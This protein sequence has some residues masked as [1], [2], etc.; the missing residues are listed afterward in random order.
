M[1]RLV[2]AATSAG[3]ETAISRASSPTTRFPSVVKA[4]I[5]SISERPPR[6]A[7]T[8]GL[9][10]STVAT[11]LVEV[12]RSMPT[13]GSR[14]GERKKRPTPRAGGC[15][16]AMNRCEAR[17]PGATGPVRHGACVRRPPLCPR[18][19]RGEPLRRRGRHRRSAE[20]A[21][22]ADGVESAPGGRRPE[23]RLHPRPAPWGGG[24]ADPAPQAGGAPA[25]ELPS[26]A[27]GPSPAGDAP[28][29]R[30]AVPRHGR[31]E[32]RT[33]PG[34]GG[35]RGSAGPGL[36]Q[37]AR[38]NTVTR[39][40]EAGGARH[41]RGP[42]GPG[43]RQ[44]PGRLG[45][46][47][48]NAAFPAR[49]AEA[50]TPELDRRG[51]RQ[52]FPSPD[53]CRER[54]ELW[55]HRAAVSISSPEPVRM[56][57][58]DPQGPV[59]S[60][61]GAADPLIGRVLNDRFRILSPLG[62][63]GM[64]KVY[65][66]VQTPLDRVVALKILNPNFPAEKD[67]AFKRRFFL[68]ASLTSKL[69]HPNTVTVI[70]YGQTEDGIYFIAMEYMEGQTL[71][72]VLAHEK[73]LPWRR[74]LDIAQQICRSLREAH[75]LGVIHRD[76]KPA[77]VMLLNE[78]DHDMVKVLD[79]GLVKSFLAA[80]GQAGD[81]EVTQN[82]VFLGSPQYMAPEQARNVADPRSDVY[83]LG[84]LVYQ[85]L[86][87]RPP[88]Q[89]KDYL[90]VI[91]QHMKESPRPV[92]DLNPN[93]E[94]P[95]EV[96]A[97]VLRC[98]Q[99]DPAAR[100][101]SMDEVLEALREVAL[102]T[103]MSGIFPER[104]TST[105]SGPMSSS[106]VHARSGSGP[107]SSSGLHSRSISGP[108][109]A[110]R[111]QVDRE[112]E[113][114]DAGEQRKGGKLLPALLFVSAVLL[115]FV[116]VWLLLPKGDQAQ[117][118]STAPAPVP[119][120]TPVVVAPKA[121]QPPPAPEK[122]MVRFHVSTEPAGAHVFI[123]RHDMGSTPTVF[124]IAA[125]SDGM[126]SAEMVLVLDGYPTQAITSGGSGDVVVN[127]RLQ[128]KVVMRIEKPVPLSKREEERE[129]EEGKAPVPVRPEA[130]AAVA[131]GA[132]AQPQVQPTSLGSTAPKP[133]AAA[134]APVP[135]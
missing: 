53:A 7:S 89:G 6:F 41:P 37:A 49:R 100:Y 108:V 94:V 103:G 88:F 19:P 129:R 44:H 111:A 2:A 23:S 32:G 67:P 51:C 131:K 124:E 14:I 80:D 54:E 121:P 73:T 90:E 102:I 16:S 118:V 69:R 59:P 1:N 38:V 36:H 63:G 71:A 104:R 86:S 120:P 92:R 75:K 61:V 62:S 134:P 47:R 84:I 107:M 68:E 56:L 114:E 9:P 30:P 72:E 91:F 83:S 12:P 106:G 4:S 130:V 98:L 135:E 109:T 70:D 31:R 126:A 60:V 96:E 26:P 81:P 46:L 112:I 50:R 123:G 27:R 11:A 55:F 64:G 22:Q 15:N 97:V 95:A 115:G 122:K 133:V 132:S 82:G 119:A 105:G 65:K 79:F 8:R 87:G 76:L 128:K 117:V 48:R 125:G 99:K 101:Q 77:N 43:R 34:H 3:R 5:K 24:C 28:G 21:G 85:M 110:P 42:G 57:E 78:A 127:A 35:E 17:G 18:A 93:A 74:V 39:R 52:R 40:A 116:V 29:H 10:F 20:R 33:R 25:S 45:R 58:G 13:T 66:A 113:I